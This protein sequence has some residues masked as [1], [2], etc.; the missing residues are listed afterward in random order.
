MKGRL[1]RQRGLSMMEILIALVVIGIGIGVFLRMEGGAGS[2]MAGNGKMLRAGQL[3][4][5]HLE[6]M[7]IGIARDTVGNWPPG[8]T[9]YSESGLKITRTVSAARS[10]KDNTLLGNVRRVD[11]IVTWGTFK[12]DSLDVETYV[13][14][15]F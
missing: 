13:A 6:A 9:S 3:V 2:S 14:K 4:E 8:D 5:K 12:T 11:L 7:R 10:P 15:R 1:E